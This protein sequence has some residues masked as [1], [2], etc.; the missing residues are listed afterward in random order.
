MSCNQVLDHLETAHDNDIGM[1]QEV[2]KFRA[3][4]GHQDPLKPIDP[5]SKGSNYYVQVEWETGKVTFEPL[6]VI[7]ADTQLLV[8][9][10]P[11]NMI[12]LL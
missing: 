12:F 7:A 8:L 5:D 4:S 3:F 9:H 10:M 1:D 2:F 11:S 6:S